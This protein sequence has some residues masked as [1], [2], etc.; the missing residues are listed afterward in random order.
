MIKK[1]MISLD[2]AQEDIN[3]ILMTLDRDIKFLQQN[4]LM[5]Y[6]LLLGIEKVTNVGAEIAFR[7]VKSL[8][9][10]EL[11]QTRNQTVHL[12]NK[13]NTTMDN[14]SMSALNVTL[15]VPLKGSVDPHK[16]LDEI[17]NDLTLNPKRATQLKRKT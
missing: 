11:D 4:G 9:N 12:R 1:R 3:L 7:H 10:E 17:A 5:D 15:K 8:K 2:I 13:M 6:S 16:T 14:R